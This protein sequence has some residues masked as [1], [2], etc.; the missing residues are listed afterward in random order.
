MS[1]GVFSFQGKY[2]YAFTSK[3]AI[4]KYAELNI[5][6]NAEGKIKKLIN[7]AKLNKVRTG[8]NGLTKEQESEISRIVHQE[9]QHIKERYNNKYHSYDN[10]IEIVL[11]TGGSYSMPKDA[12]AQLAWAKLTNYL[13]RYDTAT[14]TEIPL[15]L[16]ICFYHM[17]YAD[18]NTPTYFI[19][20]PTSGEMTITVDGKN[21]FVPDLKVNGVGEQTKIGN[22][23]Y[24]I[25]F[26]AIAGKTYA[27][28][29]NKHIESF[30][31]Y[32]IIVTLK[33]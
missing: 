25:K 30:G 31:L 23:Y 16:N 20:A 7:Q 1:F 9:R 13:D 33:K 29:L 8:N 6:N 22:H 28:T 14:I 24:E 32:S 5:I 10:I 21:N 19:T 11:R 18:R 4:D 17:A 3:A 26:N 15:P 27:I 12:A 2:V